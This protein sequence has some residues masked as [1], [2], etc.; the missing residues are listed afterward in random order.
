MKANVQVVSERVDS[1][2]GKRGKVTNKVL[3]L[4]DLDP[5]K[6]FLNT[7]DYTMSEEEAEKHSGKIQGK[8]IELG[9][10][11]MEPAFGNRLRV[12][13]AIMKVAAT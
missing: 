10:T 9:I 13:G 8:R 11:N 3:S 5:D 7:F 12:R 4:L 2:T 6:P 1:F